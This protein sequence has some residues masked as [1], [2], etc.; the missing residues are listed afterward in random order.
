[1]SG[2]ISKSK[3]K[4][5]L[6]EFTVSGIQIENTVGSVNLK[7]NEIRGFAQDVVDLREEKKTT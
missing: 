2:I 7:G 3:D 1:M 6:P 5:N 4:L